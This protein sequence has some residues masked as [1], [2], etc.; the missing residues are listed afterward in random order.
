M[1]SGKVLIFRNSQ[2]W[3]WLGTATN[4]EQI[5]LHTVNISSMAH[6]PQSEEIPKEK[7]PH[8]LSNF[9]IMRR[10]ALLSPDGFSGGVTFSWILMQACMCMRVC[11]KTFFW[12]TTYLQ[13]LLIN[14]DSERQWTLN[15]ILNFQHVEVLLFFISR[16]HSLYVKL[17]IT[18]VKPSSHLRERENICLHRN[19]YSDA[20]SYI[21]HSN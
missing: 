11:L 17:G 4:K 5:R 6:K 8:F 20:S 21:I 1:F 9:S 12:G 18:E 16:R 2:K 10:V 3:F 19:L 14:W 7:L 15:C 13:R